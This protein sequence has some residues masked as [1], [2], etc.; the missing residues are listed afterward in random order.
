MVLSQCETLQDNLIILIELI[1]KIGHHKEFLKLTKCSKHQLEELFTVV[2][3]DYQLSCLNWIIFSYN[4]ETCNRCIGKLDALEVHKP[5]FMFATAP[6]KK[7]K[8][9]KNRYCKLLWCTVELE[10]W[11]KSV[12][13]PTLELVALELSA[14]LLDSVPYIPHAFLALS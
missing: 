5:L 6:L 1:M 2:N 12:C 13:I 4:I 10:T 9:K 8:R 7:K 14:M 11:Y 3:L